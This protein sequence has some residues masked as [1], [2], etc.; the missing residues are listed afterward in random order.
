MDTVTWVSTFHNFEAILRPVS[1]IEKLATHLDVG[2]LRFGKSCLRKKKK[3]EIV[4][5]AA[6]FSFK[7]M[8]INN[9]KSKQT[10]E[11]KTQISVKC[12]R[13]RMK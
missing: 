3:N 4:L 2:V 9:K 5:Q 8:Y 10:H 1:E 11:Q 13:I 12:Q 6:H 7:K